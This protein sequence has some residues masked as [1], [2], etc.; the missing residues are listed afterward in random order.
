[1]LLAV[2]HVLAHAGQMPRRAW[3]THAVA[4][5]AVVSAVRALLQFVIF[6]GNPGDPVEVWFGRN[7]DMITDPTRWGFLFLHFAWAGRT[8]LIV[9]TNYNLLF[10]LAVPFVF[11]GWSD[12]PIFLRRALWIAPLL[13]VLAMFIG[14]IDEMRVYY[15]AY[16]VV[17]LLAA[18]VPGQLLRPAEPA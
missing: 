13:V 2:V 6:A 8:A 17:F 1:V 4:Q 5:V 14:Q 9:P 15:D 12:R 3:L 18:G 11:W 10:L 7:W 16:V